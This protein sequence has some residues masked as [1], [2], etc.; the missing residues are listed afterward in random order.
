MGPSTVGAAQTSVTTVGQ[1]LMGVGEKVTLTTAVL[2]GHVP[3]STQAAARGLGA[4]TR[5]VLQTAAVGAGARSTRV[6]ETTS[7]HRMTKEEDS[8]PQNIVKILLAREG[9][10]H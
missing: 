6:A 2:R 10:Q 3:L 1:A 4:S 5:R 7:A 9:Q 8:I